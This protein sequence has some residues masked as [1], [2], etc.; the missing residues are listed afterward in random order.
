MNRIGQIQTSLVPSKMLQRGS[1]TMA[2]SKDNITVLRWIDKREVHMIS[3]YAGA[4]PFDEILRYDKKEKTKIPITR[5]FCIQEYNKCCGGVDS[6][7]VL[8]LTILTALKTKNGTFEYFFR[9]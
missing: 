2:T 5:P 7:I 1:C 6:W 8:N 3:S 9:F 4:E